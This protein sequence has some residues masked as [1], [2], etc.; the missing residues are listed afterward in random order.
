[1]DTR[2]SRAQLFLVPRSLVSLL[3]SL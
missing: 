3:R 1:M 2:A